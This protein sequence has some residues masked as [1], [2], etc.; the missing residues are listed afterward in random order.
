MLNKE[1]RAGAYF[2]LICVVIWALLQLYISGFHP[3]AD[4]Y[5]LPT[6]SSTTD[7]VSLL[8]LSIAGMTLTDLETNE[9]ADAVD[10]VGTYQSHI[11]IKITR[12]KS[13]GIAYR[14]M[15]GKAHKSGFYLY[16]DGDYGFHVGTSRDLWIRSFTRDW[17]IKT[18]SDQSIFVWHKCV[19]VFEVCAPTESLRDDVVQGLNF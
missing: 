9:Y 3:P 5:S 7:P 16:D 14:V 6:P 19:W 13:V 18:V 2:I 8:P 12:F 1:S 17:F 4:V 11:S 15:K 10:A